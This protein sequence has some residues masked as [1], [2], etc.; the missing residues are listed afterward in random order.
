M[1]FDGRHSTTMDNQEARD[2]LASLLNKNL[3]VVATDGRMFLGQFKCTDAVR[4]APN[5]RPN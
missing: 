5:F 1:L 3:R 4:H 2:F